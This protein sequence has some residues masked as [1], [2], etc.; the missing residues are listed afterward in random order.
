[1]STYSRDRRIGASF[2]L[3][4]AFFGARHVAAKLQGIPSDFRTHSSRGS[5]LVKLPDCKIRKMKCWER[6][7][8]RENQSSVETDFSTSLI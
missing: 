8:I 6:P 7:E 5:P 1:M 2:S 4:R 3:R